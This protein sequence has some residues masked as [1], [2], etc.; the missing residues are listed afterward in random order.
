MVTLRWKRTSPVILSAT[1][2]NQA[3]APINSQCKN[4][5]RNAH[6]AATIRAPDSHTGHPKT[7]TVA[8]GGADLPQS[9]GP[10]TWRQIQG[11]RPMATAQRKFWG[12][13]TEDQTVTPEEQA[14]LTAAFAKRFDTALPK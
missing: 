1:A 6:P 8:A 10:L 7:T 12:W 4:V 13:G 3:P 11:R 14:F 5:M 9:R 2:T